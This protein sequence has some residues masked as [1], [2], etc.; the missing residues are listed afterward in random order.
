[1]TSTTA[2]KKAPTSAARRVVRS[3]L[4]AAFW[5]AVWQI[6]AW[7]VGRD[8]ILASPFAVLVRLGQLVH[9]WDFWTTVGLSLGRITLGFALAAIVGTLLATL[10]EAFRI[11]EILFSPLMSAI[12]SVPVA[13]FIIVVLL[14][15]SS[16]QLATITS[17]LIVLPVVYGNVCEGIRQRD[18]AMLEFASVFRIPRRRRVVAIDIPAVRPYFA[19]ACRIGVGLAWKSGVAAEVIGVIHGSI[20]ERLY[21]AKIFLESADVFAW[22][23][24]IVALSMACEAIV[25]RLVKQLPGGAS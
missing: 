2:A 1:M 13:S 9:T 14:W 20:G 24:V 23:I 7:I 16:S 5:V 3:A 4:V 11:V 18:R 10:A 21:E 17:F 6:V 19:A 8:F 22:T 15:A 25:L 12:R